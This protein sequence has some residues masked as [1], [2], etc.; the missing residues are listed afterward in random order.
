MRDFVD[1]L[2]LRLAAVVAAAVGVVCLVS[3]VDIWVSA[4]RIGATF[5]L[6]LL[7]GLCVRWLVISSQEK[8]TAP[9]SAPA[10]APDE[11]PASGPRDEGAPADEP[12]G[13]K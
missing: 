12:R 9:R 7:A 6:L 3:G 2:P 13:T 11:A 1:T 5:V 4:G 10:P 8:A